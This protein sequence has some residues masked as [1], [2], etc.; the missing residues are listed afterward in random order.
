MFVT[1]TLDTPKGVCVISSHRTQYIQGT[2]F[3]YLYPLTS[4][5][6]L[7]YFERMNSIVTF[8]FHLRASLRAA[9]SWLCP[10]SHSMIIYRLLAVYIMTSSFNM[11][12]KTRDRSLH[13]ASVLQQM[14]KRPKGK[15]WLRSL[16]QATILQISK[17]IHI[18]IN[19]LQKWVD[20]LCGKSGG[21]AQIE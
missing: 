8:G 5:L 16:I 17:I 11:S 1:S 6:R 15:V 4:T 18:L 9:Q 14:C 10:H 19:M 21:I 7:L 2:S 20:S 12:L 3:T 13:I